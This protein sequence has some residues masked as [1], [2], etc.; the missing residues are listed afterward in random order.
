MAS[1]PLPAQEILLKD[2][3]KIEN[4]QSFRQLDQLILYQSGTVSRSI[5]LTRIERITNA[6][7]SVFYQSESLRVERERS[8]DGRAQYIFYRNGKEAGRCF[9]DDEG[10][11]HMLS[12]SIPDGSY[13]Q[14]YDS[15]KLE[16]EFTIHNGTLNGES[17]VYYESGILE[18]QGTF[19]NGREEGLSK[20]FYKDGSKAGESEYKNGVKDGR[21][22]LFYPNGEVKALMLFEKGKAH[23]EQRMFYPTGAL[24]TTVEFVHGVKNGAIVQ[25]YES[26]KPKFQGTYLNDKLHGEVVS[27]YESGRVKARKVFSEGRILVSDSGA[28]VKPAAEPA[29]G[30]SVKNK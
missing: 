21:T 13:E 1:A 10:G 2:G 14:F 27:L 3:R 20:L 7:G 28:S 26:G 18:R 29:K 9:W 12:G 22:T 11:F 5:P 8:R 19:V 30:A 25:Y 23:G 24:E 4:I 17:R 6:D 15:G 16:R